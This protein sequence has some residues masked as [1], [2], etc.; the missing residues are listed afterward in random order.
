MPDTPM[1]DRELLDALAED[2]AHLC[3]IVST[4][5]FFPPHPRTIRARHAAAREAREAGKS[6]YV[7]D[8]D[9]LAI[10]ASNEVDARECVA[11]WDSVSIPG[12]PHHAVLAGSDDEARAKYAA[13]A[14]LSTTPA[15]P[16]TATP[17][18]AA[19]EAREAE[20][21]RDEALARAERAEATVRELRALCAEAATVLIVQ[22]AWA[23][24]G[25]AM[26]NR[27]RDAAGAGEGRADA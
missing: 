6:W 9:G 11:R 5:G 16:G 13:I 3:E 26:Y 23:G 18:D 7:V 10:C 24:R 20:R 2:V 8:R 25:S 21:E 17:T 15:T 27:L 12:A 14:A 4:P 19:R 22:I 1:V